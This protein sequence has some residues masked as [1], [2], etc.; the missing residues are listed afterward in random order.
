MK[1][2]KILMSVLESLQ[3]EIEVYDVSKYICIAY[4]DTWSNQRRKKRM[5]KMRE[6][7][8]MEEDSKVMT[9]CKR[10]H[11][12]SEVMEEKAV[13]L[14]STEEDRES[15]LIEFLVEVKKGKEIEW[16][17]YKKGMGEDDV[18]LRLEA[19]ETTNK[20]FLHKI[21]QY[22]KNNTAL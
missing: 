20:E 15:C 8:T 9:G 14:D 6:S 18:Y 4:R 17:E 13:K 5:E 11:S 12:D 19:L 2:D 3:L 16:D 10:K 1:T 21:A 7:I 22:I